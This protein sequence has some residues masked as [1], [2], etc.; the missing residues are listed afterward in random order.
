MRRLILLLILLSQVSLAQEYVPIG[1]DTNTRVMWPPREDGSFNYYDNSSRTNTTLIRSL[2]DFPTPTNNLI[3]LEDH[4]TYQIN[5]I[6]NIS[7][8]SILLGNS[9]LLTGLDKSSDGLIYTGTNDMLIIS[10]VSASIS[11][12][13]LV[14]PS[15]TVTHIC[16]E[17]NNVQTEIYHN[18]YGKSKKVLSSCSYERIIF[19]NNLLLGLTDTGLDFYGSAYHELTVLDCMFDEPDPNTTWINLSTGVWEY[20]IFSRCHTHVNDTNSYFLKAST[21]SLNITSN[22]YGYI[23]LISFGDAQRIW[24]NVVEGIV[25]GDTR[26]DI[27]NVQNAPITD[28]VGGMYT[29]NLTLVDILYEDTNTLVTGMWTQLGTMSRFS[30]STNRVTYIGV[31][32]VTVQLIANPVLRPASGNAQLIIPSLAKNGIIESSTE[33]RYI[34]DAGNSIGATLIWV[35]QVNYG[36]YF[37]LYIRNES[38]DRDV[39]IESVKIRIK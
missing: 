6:I 32:P 37:E 4:I 29:T 30:F 5:G 15:G 8:N 35:T 27:S 23:N 34:L 19:H 28:P 39:Y 1:V 26:W 31:S 36:D 21:N 14:A 38:T 9:G 12:L 2:S 7:T 16:S 17:T 18:I 24:T 13:Y 22:G 3:I 20:V 10:N 33:Q 25:S 11:R